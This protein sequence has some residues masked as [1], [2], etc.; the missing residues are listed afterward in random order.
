MREEELG[1]VLFVRQRPSPDVH[2]LITANMS[3]SLLRMERRTR[4][5]AHQKQTPAAPIRPTEAETSRQGKQGKQ[6]HCEASPVISN[7]EDEVDVPVKG[8]Q[9]L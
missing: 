9:R 6:V 3:S 5:K 7:A 8:C 2:E 4:T 1:P